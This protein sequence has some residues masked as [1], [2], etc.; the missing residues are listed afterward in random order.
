MFI[1]LS[2]CATRQTV[3]STTVSLVCFASVYLLARDFRINI[4]FVLFSSF[5]KKKLPKSNSACTLI[6]FSQYILINIYIK[7]NR[8]YLT[9]SHI[10]HIISHR[11]NN[12]RV[13][14]MD[15]VES[16]E[17][18]WRPTFYFVPH[19]YA[20]YYTQTKP[21]FI[22]SPSK[23]L[24]SH[25]SLLIYFFVIVYTTALYCYI[26]YITR[27]AGYH[28]ISCMCVTLVLQTFQNLLV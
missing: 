15:F 7:K 5:E 19:K 11:S 28:K 4:F 25:I 22:S 2:P 23:I 16:R 26:L 12:I 9:L 6:A 18:A 27:L 3:H 20:S 17:F 1:L 21:H 14:T 24:C 10:R 8:V 13:S